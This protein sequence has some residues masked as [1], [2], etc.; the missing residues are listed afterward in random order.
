ME[1][2]QYPIGRFVALPDYTPAQLRTYIDDI[3]YLPQLVEIAVQ[4]LDEYQLQTPYRPDG[5]TVAQV[6]HHLA[7]SHM[8]GYTRMKLALTEDKPVIKP[9]EEQLWAEL[10]DVKFTPVNMSITLLYALHRRWVS[11]MEHLTPEDWERTFIHPA[12]GTQHNLKTHAA[13]YS[14]HGKHHLEHIL[15][16]KERMDW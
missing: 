3:R 7:D 10:P 2:L 12:N 4:Q 11:L 1:S 14:W 16:L 9:Y 6:V 15:R 13:N 5:W 8:N